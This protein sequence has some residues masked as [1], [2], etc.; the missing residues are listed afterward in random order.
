MSKEIWLLIGHGSR[1]QEGNEEFLSLVEDLRKKNKNRRIDAAFVE[2]AEPNMRTVLEGYGD[3]EPKTVWILPLLFFGAGHSK[4]EIP[5]V[6]HEA[7]EKY[8]HVDF[9][10]GTPLG[11][12]PSLL[13]MVH[14]RVLKAEKGVRPLAKEETAILLIGRGSSDP[15][16]NGDLH[17]VSRLFWEAFR[18]GLAETCFIGVTQPDLPA[19]IKRSVQLGAKRIIAIPYFIFTGILIKRIE[20]ILSENRPVYPGV[21]ILTGEYL[22]KDPLLLSLI[23][24]RFHAIK[25]GPV[26]MNCDLCKIQF[27]ELAGQKAPAHQ[28]AHHDHQGH[29]H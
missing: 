4:A 27:P 10:Y 11:I 3:P 6:I 22:G 17:K 16:A 25:K 28:K 13:K 15:D 14:D 29:H 8:S 1:D 9:R 7:R 18:Y 24:E 2:L 20:K 26:L 23:E 5:E 21:E 19:G 12:H